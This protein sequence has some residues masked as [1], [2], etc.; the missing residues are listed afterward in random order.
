MIKQ[1]L[2]I[3][4]AAL[5]FFTRIPSPFASDMH[6]KELLNRSAKYFSL[7]GWIVGGLCAL[8]LWISGQL[9]PYSI[10]IVLSIITG[11]LVTGAFHEDGFADTCDGFGGGW[12]KERIIEIM[13]DSRIGSYGTI[14]IIL[15]L[16]TKYL[17]LSEILFHSLPFV[18][19]AAHSI[20]RLASTHCIYTHEYVGNQDTS[21]AKPLCSA[22]SSKEMMI[23][24]I[25]G[26]MPLFL[27]G[28]VWFLISI[29]PIFITK[30][31]LAKYFKKWIGG[32]TGDCLGAIQ[33]VTEIVF[34]LTVLVI[35]RFI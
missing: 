16:L 30:W 15:I 35:C 18:I 12:T 20:S 10:S 3:F 17:L 32:Y 26:I 2:K 22:I 27:L 5:T 29:V 24:L 14:G 13:K 8:V 28:S 11:I 25:L 19:I 1:E 6:S 21:K 4:F 33:Q 34:Y 9:L 31:W 23:G 7:I